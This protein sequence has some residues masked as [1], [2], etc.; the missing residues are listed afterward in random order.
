M[1][2]RQQYKDWITILFGTNMLDKR[3]LPLFVLGEAGKPQCFRNARLPPN[4]DL[5]PV[6]TQ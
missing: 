6:L 1:K 2:G 3:K 5:T 4:E